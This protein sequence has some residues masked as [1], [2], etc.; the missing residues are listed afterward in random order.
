MS[1]RIIHDSDY[2]QFVMTPP[3]MTDSEYEMYEPKTSQIRV[4]SGGGSRSEDGGLGQL[5]IV[6]PQGWLSGGNDWVA[7]VVI[8]VVSTIALMTVYMLLSRK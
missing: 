5:P 4:M 2:M 8:I 1:R 6:A 7:P 3:R